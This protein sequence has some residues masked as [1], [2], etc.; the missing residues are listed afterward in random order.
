VKTLIQRIKRRL[1]SS[2]D[3]KKSI[4]DAFSKVKTEMDEHRESI[5]AN[6]NEIQTMYEYICRLESQIE[7]MKERFDEMSMFYANAGSPRDLNEGDYSIRSADENEK[8]A[9]L[10]LYSSSE[11][12]SALKDLAR[13]IGRDVEQTARLFESLAHKGVP[14]KLYSVN[15]EKFLYLDPEFKGLQAKHNI[16]EIGHEVAHEI[17]H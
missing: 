14:I 5:N 3:D 2:Y 8:E 13:R 4:K 16:M 11:H 12:H 17:M 1:S 7:K 15:N 10:A 9:F 6:T